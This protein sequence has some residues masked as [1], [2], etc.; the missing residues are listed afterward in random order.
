MPEEH[1]SRSA[2]WFRP[3]QNLVNPVSDPSSG[4]GGDGFDDGAELADDF[5]VGEGGGAGADLGD[6]LGE[7][8]ADVVGEL[9]D[10]GVGRAELGVL[11]EELLA[12]PG[13][14]LGDAISV[15]RG[16]M[17]GSQ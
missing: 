17:V 10:R 2:L 11:L 15:P 7:A 9:I 16:C 5:L 13:A 1:R 6:G 14:E 12:L 3:S 4:G 8:D